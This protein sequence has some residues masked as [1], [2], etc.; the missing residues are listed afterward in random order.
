MNRA[1]FSLNK[2]LLREANNKLKAIS[3]YEG[4]QQNGENW[5]DFL[6]IDSLSDSWVNQK[7]I[8]R[9]LDWL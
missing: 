5:T 6:K 1:E 2:P 4:S 9:R 7:W 3:Q 8:K